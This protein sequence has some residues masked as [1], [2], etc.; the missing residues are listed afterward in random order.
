MT[1]LISDELLEEVAVCA[2]IGE[3][4]KGVRKRVDGVA[5]RVSLVA[6]FTRDPDMWDD[7]VRDLSATSGD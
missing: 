2:P 6:H 5:N 4:A 1:G 3:L 7:V